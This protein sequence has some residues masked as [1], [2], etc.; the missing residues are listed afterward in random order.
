MGC[1]FSSAAREMQNNKNEKIELMKV[2]NNEDFTTKKIKRFLIYLD[3][4]SCSGLATNQSPCRKPYDNYHNSRVDSL[5]VF[6]EP[7]RQ[8]D[9]EV[10][11]SG[12]R[13]S[14]GK[15]CERAIKSEGQQN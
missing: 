2:K 15:H 10:S 7:M 8:I 1:T 9:I 4:G 11:T 6:G 5:V 3:G 12:I 13:I 14:S